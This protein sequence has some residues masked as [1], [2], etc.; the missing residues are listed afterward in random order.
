MPLATIPEAI[1]EIRQGRMIIL[2]DDESRENEGDLV[3]AAEKVTPEAINFMAK[4]G[5]G[6]ICM[7][8]TEE[9]VQQL[10]LGM[11]VEENSS[12]R[13]TAF[14]VSVDARRDITTGISA[15]DRATTIQ[16]IVRDDARPNDL[17]TPG[18]LFPLKVRRGGVLVRAGHTEGSSDLA[19]LA[20]LKP[21]AVICEILNDDGTMARMP[22][23]EA[24]A[25]THG[26]KVASIADLIRYRRQTE[27]LV[28]RVAEANLPTTTGVFRGILYEN[29][30]DAYHHMALVMGEMSPT[31]PILVRVQSECLTGD[32]FG[33]LRC[34]CGERLRT[35]LQ[36]IGKEGRGALVYIRRQMPGSQVADVIRTYALQ[37]AGKVP[38]GPHERLRFEDEIVEYGIGAQ[39]LID[40]GVRKMRLLTNNPRRIVGIEGFGLTLLETVPIPL[41]RTA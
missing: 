8:L 26:L 24:F 21:L 16:V 13:E 34:D 1:E 4:Y 6:L 31:D 41:D 39:I 3:M 33:S 5:R 40:L 2:V 9:K 18:H 22:H 15:F 28:R 29:Q 36:M 37:D 12:L 27:V 25:K 19:R 11:M 32:V 38:Q 30:V 23:L 7:S 20:G 17:V 35:S 14:T 10:G